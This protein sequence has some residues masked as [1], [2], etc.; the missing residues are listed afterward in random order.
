MLKQEGEQ[1]DFPKELLRLLCV[2]YRMPRRAKW[3][4]VIS[5][6][7]V[8]NGTLAAGCPCATG[9]A[10]VI[11]HRALEIFGHMLVGKVTERD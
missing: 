11:M 3:G 4:E 1:L 10:K 8:V 9:P 2:S 6:E 7:L 5:E